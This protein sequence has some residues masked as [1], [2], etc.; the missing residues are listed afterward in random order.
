MWVVLY[1]RNQSASQ[2]VGDNVTRLTAPILVVSQLMVVVARLPDCPA[3]TAHRIDRPCRT[4]FER[5][6]AATERCRAHAQQPVDVIRHDDPGAGSR[7]TVAQ[8]VC[9]DPRQRMGRE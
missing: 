1:P 9:H 8:L 4:G 5:L 6:Y 3:C 7:R 2:G